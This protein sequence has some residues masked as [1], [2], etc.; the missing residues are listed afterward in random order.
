MA[1]E[2]S[3][4]W[5]ETFLSPRTAAPVQRELD[6]VQEH[7]PLHLFRRILDVPC[8]IGRH[9]GP[10]ASLG[11]ELLG[12]D[13][14]PGVVDVARQVS[15]DGASFEVL[16]VSE[17]D[18]LA[19]SF[20]AVLCLWQSFGYGSQAENEETLASMARRVRPGGRVLLDVYNANALVHLPSEATDERDG[21][22]VQTR[23]T[24]DNRRFRVEIQYSDSGDEDVH[25]WLVY[26]PEELAESG[27]AVGL[28][29][30]FSCAWFHE[31][32]PAS[33][34]HQRMQLLFEVPN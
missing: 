29:L 6:F 21:R 24:L 12:V 20:D 3:A 28:S 4:T 25:D 9:A 17:L 32:T 31:G 10:L 15:P 5:F 22:I 13:R 34:E 23:R 33:S 2:F 14:D 30:V 26:T 18:T 27:S 16:D 7:L 11:Y 8:G 1:N 19:D